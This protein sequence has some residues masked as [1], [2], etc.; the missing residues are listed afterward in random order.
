MLIKAA[1]A[2]P[3]RSLW[4]LLCHCVT[5]LLLLA[6]SNAATVQVSRTLCDHDLALPAAR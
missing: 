1:M 2:D 5:L 4:R 6:R 3:N